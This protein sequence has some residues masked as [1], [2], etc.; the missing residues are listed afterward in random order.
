MTYSSCLLS[1][2]Y[3]AEFHQKP[4]ESS[5]LHLLQQLI[6]HHVGMIFQKLKMCIEACTNFRHHWKNKVASFE[7]NNRRSLAYLLQSISFCLAI[8]NTLSSFLSR[9]NNDARWDLYYVESDHDEL[10]AGNDMP[11][12]LWVSLALL[13]HPTINDMIIDW[14]AMKL[15]LVDCSPV[16]NDSPVGRD[17]VD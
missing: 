6:L 16:D 17:F 8:T 11:M 7:L 15:Q 14:W 5:I 10:I 2:I 9:T 4:V 1:F 3:A 12:Q 13:N